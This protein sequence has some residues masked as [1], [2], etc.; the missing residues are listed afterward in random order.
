MF[1]RENWG[2][3]GKPAVLWLPKSLLDSEWDETLDVS[4]VFSLFPSQLLDP[5]LVLCWLPGLA[6]YCL[7]VSPWPELLI[8]E[9]N[10]GD[11]GEFLFPPGT[12]HFIFCS[13]A[14]ASG[15]RGWSCI[16]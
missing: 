5:P 9:Y 15:N 12:L 6:S 8:L 16:A 1:G 7:I 13:F 10:L 14:A 4:V 11:V 3:L 2:T